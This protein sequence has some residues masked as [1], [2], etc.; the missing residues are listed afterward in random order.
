MVCGQTL[1]LTALQTLAYG[2][3]AAKRLYPCFSNRCDKSRDHYC[4]R[5][6]C[7][8]LMSEALDLILVSRNS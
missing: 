8:Y 5:E 6:Y 3:V 2:T 1:Q 4:M 7:D